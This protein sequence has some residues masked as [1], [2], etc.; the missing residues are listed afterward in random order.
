MHTDGFFRVTRRSSSPPRRKCSVSYSNF[1]NV[2]QIVRATSSSSST[3]NT[4]SLNC[5]SVP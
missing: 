2:S 5:A 4:R 1:L 3:T